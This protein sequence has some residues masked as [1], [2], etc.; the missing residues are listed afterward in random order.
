MEAFD[1]LV[2][3][4]HQYKNAPSAEDWKMAEA[5][6]SPLKVFFEAL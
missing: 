3:Q 2:K 1:E 6:C 5:I 4:Y